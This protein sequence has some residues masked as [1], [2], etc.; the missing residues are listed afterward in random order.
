MPATFHFWGCCFAIG[1]KRDIHG[2]NIGI[3]DLSSDRRNDLMCVIKEAYGHDHSVHYET[4]KLIVAITGYTN[5]VVASAAY[6]VN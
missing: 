6:A 1:A 5:S 4:I 2:L 3:G